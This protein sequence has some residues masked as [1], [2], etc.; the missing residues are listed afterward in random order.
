MELVQHVH[1]LRPEA[2]TERNLRLRRELHVTED[3]QA[4]VR[5]PGLADDGDVGV[6]QIGRIAQ[7]QY[8]CAQRR[9]RQAANVEA[10]R[11]NGGCISGNNGV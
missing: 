9:I 11:V 10:G 7:A 4:V 6:R 1:L 8:F 5:E 2:A 3:Q